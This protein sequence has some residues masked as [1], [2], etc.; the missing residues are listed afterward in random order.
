MIRSLRVTDF[1]LSLIKVFQTHATGISSY[2]V[3]LRDLVAEFPQAEK[4]PKSLGHAILL[5]CNVIWYIANNIL[6]DER[7]ETDHFSL[8]HDRG[9]ND[10]VLLNTFNSLKEDNTLKNHALL[11]SIESTG[12][13]DEVRLQAADFLAFESFK[14]VERQRSKRERRKSMQALLDLDSFAGRASLILPEGLK[15]IRNTLNEETWEL[16][17]RKARIGPPV[18]SR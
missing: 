4:D 13:G 14:I 8:V 18:K 9:S 7:W 6:G 16:L 2:S 15:Q 10:G 1:T 17:F 12:W 11:D 5:L 3:D